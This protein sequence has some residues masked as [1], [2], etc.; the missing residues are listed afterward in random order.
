MLAKRY[1][2]R[3]ILALWFV[4]GLAALP[5]TAQGVGAIGGTVMDASGAVLPAASVTLASAQGTVG[6]NQ[7]TVTDARGAYQFSRLVPGTYSVRAQMQGFRPVQQPNIVVNADGTARADM[8]L[9]IGAFEEAIVVTGGAPLLDTATALKKTAISRQELDALSNRTDVWSIARVLPGVV[10]N[11]IDVGGTEAFLQSTATVRGSS[12]E[13]KSM[14]DGMDMSSLTGNGTGVVL[15][16]DPYAFEE[17][18][19]RWARAP[20]RIPPAASPSTW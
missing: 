20:R 17:T 10:M 3:G 1:V 12:T 13:N 11:K 4:T 8:R 6:G 2:E 19:F 15:Y 7:E 9:E 18:T 5:L 16:L 14:I